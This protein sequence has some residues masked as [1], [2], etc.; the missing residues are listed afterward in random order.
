MLDNVAV[1]AKEVLRRHKQIEVDPAEEFDFQ[2]VDLVHGD[3]P[4]FGIKG[5]GE[6]HVIEVLGSSIKEVRMMRWTLYPLMINEL[7][8]MMRSM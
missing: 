1:V 8:W 3:P 7:R 2:I 6:V 5:I 4:H